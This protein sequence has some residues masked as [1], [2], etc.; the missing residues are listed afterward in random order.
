[1]DILKFG[2]VVPTVEET[3]SKIWKKYLLWFAHQHANFRKEEMN[4]IISM[5]KIT[6]RLVF[7]STDHP[8][9]IVELSSP[10]EA[11]LIASRSVLLRYCIELW[12]RST[13]IEVLH[14]DLKSYPKD[15][16][17]LYLSTTFKVVVE[18]FCKHY[19]Q[20]EKVEKIETFNYLPLKG[21]V[22]LKNPDTTLFYIEYY[23]IESNSIPEKP[24]ELFFGRWIADGQRDTIQKLSLKSRKFIGNTSMDPQLSIIMANQARVKKGDM[25][26]DPFVGTGSLLIIASIFGGYTFGTDIDF[27]MLHARTRP[28]R[29]SQKIRDKDESIA[30]NMEQ[31][32]V[33]S[34]FLDV[35]VSDF[36]RTLWRTDMQLDAIITD[37]PYGI[38]EAVERVGTLKSNP[39]IEDD[40]I[41][42][43]SKV[44]YKLEHLFIDLLIFSVK[45]LRLNGRVVFWF[46]LF[47][48][49]YSEDQLPFHPCL[50]LVASSEQ[51]LSNYTSRRL[52][53][54]E[55]IKEPETDDPA[56]TIGEANFRDQ[57]FNMRKESR[58]VRRLRQS[59][60][61]A[62]QRMEWE[63]RKTTNGDKT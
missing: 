30:S 12:A 50:T 3:M 7:E 37:P 23:G 27:L 32:G 35:L 1:M 47:R 16:I 8:F 22:N 43:P 53:T 63:M 10:D 60:E 58:T 49:K 48:G 2:Y 59:G 28:S 11:Y 20:R 56:C 5:F 4:S 54:Y 51:I 33:K 21:S 26:L 61:R 24:I 14:S 18:T 44:I 19:T 39:F 34:R 40:Q 42:Y 62:R 55:K 13:N 46:P 57:Y 17:E 31:Y 29:I 52:L 38:R 45:H 25:V 36:S 9:W 41:H 6:L 15:E